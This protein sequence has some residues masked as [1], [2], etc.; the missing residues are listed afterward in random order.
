MTQPT[1]RN[2][3]TLWAECSLELW[4]HV[5]GTV[6]RKGPKGTLSVTSRKKILYDEARYGNKSGPSQSY[7]IYYTIDLY[8]PGLRRG[9][10]CIV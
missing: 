4:A 8:I 9:D 3:G 6:G 1:V 10:S 7:E 2:Y 5:G